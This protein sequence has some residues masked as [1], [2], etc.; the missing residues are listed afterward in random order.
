M[1]YSVCACCKEMVPMYE[2]Y[3]KSCL[4]KDKSL[5]QVDDFHDPR[6][7]SEPKPEVI[8]SHTCHNC[9]E[10]YS[11][12]NHTVCPKCFSWPKVQP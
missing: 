4:Q 9:G 1:S 6:R 10:N 12:L 5:V 3:C 7:N 2:K 8:A 11:W